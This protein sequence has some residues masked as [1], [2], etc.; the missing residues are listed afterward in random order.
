MLLSSYLLL[1]LTIPLEVSLTSSAE[2]CCACV[3]PCVCFFKHFSF[4]CCKAWIKRVKA[5]TAVLEASLEF[6]ELSYY[7]LLF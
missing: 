4:T 2:D 7:E 3:C 6:Q 5:W 1:F